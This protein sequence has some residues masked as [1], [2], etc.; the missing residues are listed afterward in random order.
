MKDIVRVALIQGKP[1]AQVDDPRNVGHAMRLLEK[2]RG[3]DLDLACLPEY[4]PWTG[5]E[6]LADAAREGGLKL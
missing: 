1:Y 5:E 2:C 4:F 3:K 6:I